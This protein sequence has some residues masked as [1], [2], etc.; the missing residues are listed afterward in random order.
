MGITLFQDFKDIETETIR[1][2]DKLESKNIKFNDSS[3]YLAV[4]NDSNKK[5]FWVD[6]NGAN[7]KELE[8]VT[9]LNDVKGFPILKD[10]LLVSKDSQL[11]FAKDLE[12][13]NLNVDSGSINSIETKKITAD[14]ANTITINSN[15]VLCKVANAD[16]L[17]SNEAKI[18]NLNTDELTAKSIKADDLKCEKLECDEFKPTDIESDNILSKHI[19]SEEIN[20]GSLQAKDAGIAN[21][22][23]QNILTHRADI[24]E[25]A[26][27]KVLNNEEAIINDLKVSNAHI[28]NLKYNKIIKIIKLYGSL[29]SPLHLNNLDNKILDVNNELGSLKIFNKID[30]KCPQN[31]FELINL[32]EGD[33]TINTVSHNQFINVRYN[34]CKVNEKTYLFAEFNRSP[35]NLIV[36]IILER[37]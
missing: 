9:E 32:P 28:D 29:E 21:L 13:T 22:E 33:Y 3:D 26:N 15:S 4:Y 31:R 27:I 14:V 6:E 37:I 16:K 17:I 2:S 12:I 36:Q 20:T 18:T 19:N 35:D 23:A 7:I 11:E 1:I 25:T 5:I 8:K 24:I 10:G 34:L 30:N